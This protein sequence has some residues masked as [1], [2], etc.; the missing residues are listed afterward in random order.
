MPV[1]SF[2]KEVRRHGSMANRVVLVERKDR[3]HHNAGAMRAYADATWF[4]RQRRWWQIAAAQ[5]I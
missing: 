4:E 5:K 3:C 2:G 1:H